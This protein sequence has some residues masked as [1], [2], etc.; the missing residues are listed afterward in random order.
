MTLTHNGGPGWAD[1]ALDL[2]GR[3]VKE[4]SLGGLTEFGKQVVIEMNRIGKDMWFDRVLS[5]IAPIARNQE[6]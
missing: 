3:F 6:C 5:Y 2:E 1:P 4:A